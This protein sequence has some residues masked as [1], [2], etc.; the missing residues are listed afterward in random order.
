MHHQNQEKKTKFSILFWLIDM[1]SLKCNENEDFKVRFSNILSKI[2]WVMPVMQGSNSGLFKLRKYPWVIL[3]C[4][5]GLILANTWFVHT[6]SLKLCVM[7]R[8]R[9]YCIMVLL[10]LMTYLIGQNLFY[11]VTT[12]M[13]RCLGVWRLNIWIGSLNMTIWW[14]YMIL[15][16]L[17]SRL[18]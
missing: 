16:M 6:L 15:V 5:I 1:I 12:T 3:H 11:D 13:Q 10:L 14:L 4:Q 18:K 8:F 2:F 7:D 17:K 9:N